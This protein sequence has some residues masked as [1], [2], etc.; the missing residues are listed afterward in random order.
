M[1]DN[2]TH[3]KKMRHPGFATPTT[4]TGWPRRKSRL[5]A[6]PGVGAEFLPCR[7]TED[8]DVRRSLMPGPPSR[9]EGSRRDEW[10]DRYRP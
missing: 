3:P 1:N 5:P 4:P 2:S 7:M 6:M 9:D 8:D 10:L